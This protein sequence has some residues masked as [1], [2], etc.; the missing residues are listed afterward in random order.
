[1]SSTVENAQYCNCTVVNEINDSSKIISTNA[2]NLMNTDLSLT[3]PPDQ[4]SNGYLFTS[5]G[6]GF[7]GWNLLNNQVSSIVSLSR[8]TITDTINNINSSDVNYINDPSGY[9]DMSG[10]NLKLSLNIG[11]SNIYYVEITSNLYYPTEITSSAI[12]TITMN[13]D[14]DGMIVKSEGTILQNGI[15]GQY[16]CVN[17][18]FYFDYSVSPGLVNYIFTYQASH[19]QTAYL[20]DMIITIT[21]V[22]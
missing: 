15:L 4:G 20:G 21:K 1:M 17:I 22:I 16:K 14:P 10:T 5:L 11:I 13:T 2:S 7:T 6:S 19:P 9:F 18:R 3:M 8:L 12:N